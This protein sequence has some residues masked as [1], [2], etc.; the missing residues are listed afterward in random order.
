MVTGV[1]MYANGEGSHLSMHDVMV[2]NLKEKAY[3]Y[4]WETADYKKIDKIIN[5][6]DKFR[7]NKS[8][9]YDEV[10]KFT[11]NVTSDHSIGRWQSIADWFYETEWK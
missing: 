9:I 2:K 6:I 5:G 4:A 3:R 8:N 10:K 7:I 1:K 11:K